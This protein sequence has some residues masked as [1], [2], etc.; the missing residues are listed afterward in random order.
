MDLWRRRIDLGWWVSLDSWVMNLWLCCVVVK[1]QIG[2]G[3]GCELWIGGLL[4][5]CEA[6]IGGGC[7]VVKPR[8]AVMLCFCEA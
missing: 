4:C 5:C 3:G 8:S 6:Q 2:G 1:P 7:I